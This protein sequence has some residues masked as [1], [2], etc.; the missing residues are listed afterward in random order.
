V[1]SNYRPLRASFG[2]SLCSTLQFSPTVNLRRN[3]GL[4]LVIGVAVRV[5]GV[6][7]EQTIVQLHTEQAAIESE[8]AA[9]DARLVHATDEQWRDAICIWHQRNDSRLEQQ[10]AR[11]EKIF[12]EN[13]S[14]VAVL[15]SRSAAQDL[16]VPL[17]DAVKDQLAV[18]DE[19]NALHRQLTDAHPEQR[20]EAAVAWHRRNALRLAR[21]DQRLQ[22]ALESMVDTGARVPTN[23]EVAVPLDASPAEVEMFMQQAAIEKDLLNLHVTL[24]P[25]T[26]TERRDAILAWHQ[27][28]A[29]R[30]EEQRRLQHA[31][32]EKK[33]Q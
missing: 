25:V 14:K 8:L 30:Q 18:D 10:R 9:L 6:E 15:A 33:R 13:S 17:R 31:F 22:T 7:P 16:P 4:A 28:D 2:C 11:A 21:I 5:F 27:R 19:L 20:R 23:R 12:R 32:A 24:A 26:P 3:I 1:V 29:L